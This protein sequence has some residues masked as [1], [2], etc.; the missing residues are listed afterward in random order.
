L[1]SESKLILSVGLDIG[2]TTSHLVFSQLTLRSDPLAKSRKLRVVDRKIVFRGDIHVTP[3]KE[4][5]REIDYEA[6]LPLIEKDYMLAGFKYSDIESGAVIITGESSRKENAQ[7]VIQR[8]A[9]ESGKFVSASAGPHFESIISAHGSGATQIAKEH[10]IKLIHT[11]IGGGTSNIAYID[12]GNIT[13]TS[14]INIGGRLIA[15]DQDR[16]ITRI[17]PAGRKI[18]DHLNLKLQIGDK[19]SVVQ[20]Q[21]ACSFMASVLISELLMENSEH[22]KP[23]RITEP[24]EI[25]KQKAGISYSFSGGVAE[26][27][28]GQEDREFNDL[29]KTL[30]LAIK[31]EA[32]EK[33]LKLVYVHERIRATVIGACE[34][35]LQVSGPTTYSSPS[36]NLPQ[37][38]VPV[39]IVNIR[40]RKLTIRSISN[41]ITQVLQS[42]DMIQNPNPV[43]LAFKGVIPIQY[44]S[45]KTLSLG[46]SKALSHWIKEKIPI[47]LVFEDD[48]GNTI[49][50][51]MQRENVDGNILSLDEIELLEGDF[52]DVGEP[53]KDSPTI[54]PVVI[55]T[56]IL[57]SVSS[58]LN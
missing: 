27:I 10:Q 36:I 23:F 2:T 41:A 7:Q 25:P 1:I 39:A 54:Y 57:G 40:N 14:C 48:I 45:L 3:L 34:F 19:F 58:H 29:G 55:K 26:F 31:K 32:S 8:I 51:I 38:D 15:Y 28:Y 21:K 13:S 37:K 20:E 30:G 22:S 6:L 4:G 53:L 46:I 56:I 44:N 16:I 18:L 11:D 5:D 9:A 35:T 33:K 52:L 17:E 47:I 50:N 12:K 42:F 49:G 24:L 43:A